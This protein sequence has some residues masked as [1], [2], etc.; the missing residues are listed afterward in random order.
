ME[1][2]K[3][4]PKAHLEGKYESDR[5]PVVAVLSGK[6][7]VGKSIIST[8]LAVA[9]ASE[10]AGVLL[11]DC[12]L[13]AGQSHILLG[14]CPSSGLAQVVRREKSLGEVALS[15]GGGVTL[16]PGGP[17]GGSAMDLGG[18][19]IRGLVAE[20]SVLAPFSRALILD[21]G[22]GHN[23]ALGAI[24]DTADVPVVV[25]T[26]EP[27]A[28]RATLAMLEVLFT[29]RPN[30][31]AHLLV[32]MATGEQDAVGAYRRIVDALLPVFATGVGL[33]G[34]LPYDMEVTRSLW[35]YRPVILDTPTSRAARAFH[36]LEAS[37]A[38]L[39]GPGR[40]TSTSVDESADRDRPAADQDRGDQARAA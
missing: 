29:E 18:K 8:N 14:L 30:A 31:K 3:P 24:V 16:I 35:R 10:R 22:P 17:C 13:S 23:G 5:P 27:T 37:V 12:D 26:P 28:I 19:E 11:L 33:L 34:W 15:A 25:C 6:G 38:A 2:V 36:A 9:L 4:A 32:N 39:L 7:G 20:M 1:L 40:G 21:C